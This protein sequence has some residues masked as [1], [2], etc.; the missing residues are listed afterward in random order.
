[1]KTKDWLDKFSEI[2]TPLLEEIYGKTHALD[3]ITKLSPSIEAT[4]DKLHEA[5]TL[6]CQSGSCK[7]WDATSAVLITYADS[8]LGDAS[9]LQALDQLLSHTD[10]ELP[11]V[12]LLPFFPFT[13]D[14]GFSVSDYLAVNPAVGTWQDIEKLA[15]SYTLM[16][17][18]VINHLSASHQWFRAY[19]CGEFQDFF[20]QIDPTSDDLSQVTRPRSTSLF[21]P[22]D[23]N[24]EHK[25]VWATFSH[26]QIDVN[27]ASPRVFLEFAKILIEYLEKGA[28]YIRLDAV[29][30]LWKE[31]GTTCMHLPQTHSVIKILRALAESVNPASVIITETNVPHSENIS[32]LGEGDEAHIVYNFSLP[33]MVLHALLSQSSTRLSQWLNTLTPFPR[34]CTI[35]NIL[36]T[37]DGIGLRP[38]EG[39]IPSEELE[40]VLAQLENSGGRISMRTRPDGSLAPYEA[41]ITFFDAL[42]GTIDEGEDDLQ[43]ERFIAAHAISFALPGIPAVYILSLL[44]VHNDY[45]L[46]QATGANRSINRSKLELSQILHQLH[47][48][49]SETSRVFNG[50]L[51]LLRIRRQQSAFSPEAPAKQVF[52]DD[53]LFC[54]RR[55]SQENSQHIFAI[56]N[57]TKSTIVTTCEFLDNATYGNLLK[58]E[59]YHRSS[60]LTLAPYKSVWLSSTSN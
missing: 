13:S 34:G 20:I 26:D 58:D 17:D 40:R 16:F 50:I 28:T 2:A 39:L 38:A 15:Q 45:T 21:R 31:K 1:M 49:N 43:V 42:K 22:T 52:L 18:F 23:I 36:S 7:K 29:G 10:K 25:H 53:A 27:F 11:V 41:N 48:P 5:G 32:Y 47:I 59:K 57:V 30:F 44:G 60:V 33:P 56:T 14:D 8:I 51:G 55:G 3:I 6:I 4:R 24:G 9:P 37:H 19:Q 35:L 12:H 46:M 54:V